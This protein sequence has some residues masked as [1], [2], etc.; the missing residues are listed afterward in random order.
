MTNEEQDKANIIYGY[1]RDWFNSVES[2]DASDKDL[3]EYLYVNLSDKA[4]GHIYEDYDNN[5]I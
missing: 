3:L 5:S 4:K 1:L 2:G